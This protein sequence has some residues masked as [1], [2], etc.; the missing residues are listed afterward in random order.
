MKKY[1]AAKTLNS[2]KNFSPLLRPLMH[3]IHND[4]CDPVE[5]R[6]ALQSP[7]QH[8]RGAVQQSGGRCLAE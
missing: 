7:Q 3:L 5:L 2:L 8:A 4:V 1:K 6:L